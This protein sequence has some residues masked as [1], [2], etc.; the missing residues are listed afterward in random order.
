MQ[1]TSA[2]SGANHLPA[3]SKIDRDLLET[4]KMAVVIDTNYLIYDLGLIQALSRLA[5]LEQLV[6]VIPSAVVQE[7]DNMKNS[8]KVT[9]SF[10]SRP[11]RISDLS[12]AA[13]N[14]ISDTLD[15]KDSTLR[16]QKLSEFLHPPANDVKERE[17]ADDRILD[18][19]LYIIE[20][21][22]LPVAMLT[23]DRNLSIKARANDCPTCSDWTNGAYGLLLAILS[24]GG[25][26]AQAPIEAIPPEMF[27]QGS[28]ASSSSSQA[29]KPLSR[30]AKKAARISVK[31]IHRLKDSSIQRKGTTLKGEHTM[32]GT[33]QRAKRV[34]GRVPV[35]LVGELVPLGLP[36]H[37]PSPSPAAPGPHPL[38]RVPAL[39]RS[40]S[41]FT[42]NMPI[43]TP[44][45]TTLPGGVVDLTRGIYSVDDD[46]DIDMSDDPDV[47]YIHTLSASQRSWDSVQS[48][49][50]HPVPTTSLAHSRPVDLTSPADGEPGPVLIYLDEDIDRAMQERRLPMMS[51]SEVDISRGI[52]EFLRTGWECKFT[53]LLIKQFEKHLGEGSTY[54]RG[55][56]E[57]LEEDFA[58]PPWRSATVMLTIVLYYWKS[59]FSDIFPSNLPDLIRGALP[60]VMEIEGLKEC[61]DTRRVLPPRLR[62]K[63][64]NYP[65]SSGIAYQVDGALGNEDPREAEQRAETR[66]LIY[67]VKKMLAQCHSIENDSERKHRE[68]V[69]GDLVAWEKAHSKIV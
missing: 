60:W 39:G 43:N 23:R 24:S 16:C 62:F 7:L 35:A 61:P 49:T 5:Y 18:C 36:T 47:Q 6:I 46:M 64:F 2:A 1:S 8:N 59:V 30:K 67:L 22:K 57:K 9:D 20:R 68:M 11:A 53:D 38:S 52:A 41:E 21:R 40:S 69:V 33:R 55:W 19:C 48:T 56:R 44:N 14:F 66:K 42:F 34:E 37:A 45:I 28:S 4:A 12:R 15:R 29:P 58:P 25:L 32:Q 3:L 27:D 65:A 51:K 54:A 50:T 13:S 17:K 26:Q 31:E 63:P 10:G